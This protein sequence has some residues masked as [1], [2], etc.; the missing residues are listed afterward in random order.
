MTLC[1]LS[2]VGVGLF[3]RYEAL[4]FF[5]VVF[6][7]G[8]SV[9][10]PADYA[11]LNKT[12]DPRRMGRAFSVHTFAGHLGFVAAPVTVIALT[13]LIGWR[14]A[15]I[16]SGLGGIGIG[17]LMF[18]NRYLL[19]DQPAHAHPHEEPEPGARRSRAVDEPADAHRLRFLRCDLDDRDKA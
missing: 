6:G 12:V 8:D 16:L 1:G 13:E 3:P 17:V 11:I 2:L 7:I 4:L 15:I 14:G 18:A 9:I 19:G 5:M 10:H